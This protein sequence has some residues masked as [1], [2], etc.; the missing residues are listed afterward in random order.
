M[1][2][3]AAWLIAAAGL[4]SILAGPAA[5]QQAGLAFDRTQAIE[6]EADSLEIDQEKRL[7]VF[8][9]N[10]N[11]MQGQIRLSADTLRVHYAGA[12]GAGQAEISQIDAEGQV[13]FSTTRETAQGDRGT[14]DVEN[15]IITLTGAV[16]V[17][18]GDS[19][20]RGR[21]VVLNLVTGQSTVDSGDG[22]AGDGRVR[23]LFVPRQRDR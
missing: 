9:G 11:A 14:Y 10:V 3:R 13:F 4:I 21:R 18:R 2:V 22:E 23:G 1:I 17:T 16:V 7:A 20:I 5:A 12:A 19:V 8:A 6:I 15:G